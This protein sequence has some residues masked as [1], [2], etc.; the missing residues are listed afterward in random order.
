MA[1]QA[2][3]LGATGLI[4]NHLLKQLL[5]HDIY[6]TV[7]LVG[8]R[9]PDIDDPRIETV[10]CELDELAGCAPATFRVDVV[11]CCLG[12]TLRKAGSRDAFRK[13]DHDYCVAA[14]TLAKAAGVRH[15][16]MV[17]AVNANANGVS[18]YARVKGETERDVMALGLPRVT[19]MQPSL[20]EGERDEMRFAEEMGIKAMSLVKPLLGWTRADWLPVPAQHVAT[21][22]WMAANTDGTA[23]QRLRY[24]DIERLVEDSK[25]NIEH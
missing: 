9:H 2:L 21:A 17:S 13:V 24:G 22:M 20:L 12:T 25:A 4:G 18:Y 3:L 11:F 23:C 1:G 15:F 14:A 6:D 16:V 19:F 5:T 10:T 8:R 7:R